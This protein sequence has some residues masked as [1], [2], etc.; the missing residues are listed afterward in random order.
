MRWWSSFDGYQSLLRVYSHYVGFGYKIHYKDGNHT[1]FVLGNRCPQE[2]CQYNALYHISFRVRFVGLDSTCLLLDDRTTWC[3]CRALFQWLDE[4]KAALGVS[5]EKTRST[6]SS[7]WTRAF[8]RPHDSESQLPRSSFH[9]TYVSLMNMMLAVNV[10][11]KR[12]AKFS[13]MSG[14]HLTMSPLGV[15]C[16]WAATV[17][18]SHCW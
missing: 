14:Q 13:T 6:S 18:H 4:G 5:D 10:R 7:W 2:V 16:C 12:R 3:N 8:Q 9:E 1:C 15:A 11:Q 17:H